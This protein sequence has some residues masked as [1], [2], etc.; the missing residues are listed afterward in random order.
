MKDKGTCITAAMKKDREFEKEIDY[1]RY[2]K[3]MYE[4]EHKLRQ[5]AEGE[6]T[7]VKGIGQNSP[8]MKAAKAKIEELNGILDRVKLD[9]NNLYTRVADSLEVNEHHQELNGK[10]QSRITE[11]E[12]DNRKL[13][14]QIEDKV[15]Q[16]RRSGM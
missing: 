8:E 4:K 14:N 12:E 3:D 15:N 11:V 10:L 16:M 9:N 2:W 5:E 13:A 1:H 6:M 7:I